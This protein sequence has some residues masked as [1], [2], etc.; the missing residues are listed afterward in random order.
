MPENMTH[1]NY[2][3]YKDLVKPIQQFFLETNIVTTLA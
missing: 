3:I 1:N 2:D